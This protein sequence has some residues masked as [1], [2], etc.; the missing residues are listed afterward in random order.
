MPDLLIGLLCRFMG[1]RFVVST[2]N[3]F[4]SVIGRASKKNQVQ[5]Q[6]TSTNSNLT[7][8]ISVIT[9]SGTTPVRQR[10]LAI[11]NIQK[12]APFTSAVAAWV[13]PHI[14]AVTGPSFSE[15]GL[16]SLQ[17]I[18]RMDLLESVAAFAGNTLRFDN[19]GKVWCGKKNLVL[20]PRHLTVRTKRGEKISTFPIT[21]EIS[22]ADSGE[23]EYRAQHQQAF[24]GGV[25][26]MV[27]DACRAAVLA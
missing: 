17:R 8:L 16:T 27:V 2:K 11:P 13:I 4:V 14:A 7:L 21:V 12:D 6:I 20:W 18:A 22:N 23:F 10:T 9:A 19:H 5:V 25:D 1:A 26:S 24:R 3:G 15:P